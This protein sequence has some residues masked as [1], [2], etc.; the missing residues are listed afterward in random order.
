MQRRKFIAG[1]GSLAAA[2][3]V[4]IGTG[5]FTTSSAGRSVTVDVVNDESATIG[6][7]AG[8]DP[9]IWINDDGELT[10]DLTGDDG[11]GVNINS[12]YTWGDHDTP[13]DDY[14]F[15][16]TNNDESTYNDVTLTYEVEDD[17]WIDNS[18]SWDN[19]SFIRFTV[20]GFGYSTD[21]K[22]PNN[23]LSTPNPNS[24]SVM[25]PHNWLQFAPGDE[26]YVVVDVDTTGVDATTEDDL[27]GELTIEVSDP[28]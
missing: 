13:A 6:L 3:A 25:G 16:I 2:G 18:T 10:L 7:F 11:E 14:A 27:T 5:A 1:V 19:E 22:T 26:W 24:R 4:G 8:D 17:S 28:A 12:V 23:Q 9:D 21:I 20:Y 15:K